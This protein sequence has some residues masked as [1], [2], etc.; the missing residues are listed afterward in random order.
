M[1]R[2]KKGTLYN[3]VFP[4]VDATDGLSIES[5][6]TASD[7]N[8]A[9]TKKWYGVAHGSSTAAS[10]GTISKAT[11]LVHSGIFQQTLNAT[12]TNYDRVIAVFKHASCADQ[13]MIVDFDDYDDSDI[14]SRISDVASDLRSYLVG[15]SGMLSDVDSQLNLNA[16]LA[17]DAHSAA[18]QANSRTLVIQSMVSDVDSQLLLNASMISDVQSA[19]DSQFL[20]VTSNLSDVDS[21]L[22][23]NASMI[24]DVQSAVALLATSNYLSQVH[25]D[26]AS[27]IGAVT[28]TVSASDMSDIASRVWATTEGARVD[29]RVLLIL[30]NV[31][32]VQSAVALL[33]TSNYLSQVHSDLTSQIGAIA[34]TI[35]DSNISD[36]ASAVQAILASDMSDILSAAQQTN[37][38]VLVVQSMVSDV[39]SALTVHDAAMSDAVS[40]VASALTVH[41]A[42]ISN[43]I[44]ALQSDLTSK[45]GLLATSDYLSA[46]HSDIISALG[47]ISLALTASDISDI[48]SAVAAAVTTVTASDISDIA[49][50]VQAI[51]ASDMSDIL[52][53]AQ[54]GNSRVLVV[55]SM[56]S[57]VYSLVSD[58]QSDFQSR[59]PKAV[60]TNSQLSDLHSDLRSQLDLNASMISDIQSA[61]DS[62]FTIVLSN[63]S[64][65]DSEVDLVRAGVIFSRG[66]AQAGN[67]NA[68]TLAASEPSTNSLFNDLT[69]ALV[70]GTGFGQARPV[71]NY[72]GA[73]RIATVNPNWEIA[74]DST[75][76]YILRTDFLGHS[77]I[78]QIQDNVVSLLSRVSDVDSALS[79]QFLAV[80]SMISDVDSQLDLNASMIS[81][82]DSALTLH[83]TN[84]SAAVSD[85]YSLVQNV[86]SQLLVT[87]SLLSDVDSALTL[88]DT[89]MSAALSDVESQVDLLATSNYLSQVH[90]DIMSGLGAVSVTLT[91]SDISDIASA[92]SAEGITVNL[93]ASDMSDI[94][95]RVWTNSTRTLTQSA[96]SVT[97]AV[98]GDTITVYRGTTWTIALTGLGD[99]S[100]YDKIYFSAKAS[101]DD[102]DTEAY[103]RVYNNASGL[104]RINQAA[105]TAA[106]NGTITIDDAAAGDIT[107]TINEAETTGL[108]IISGLSYDIKG[109]DNDGDVDLISIGSK[110][111]N[112]AGD[113]TRAIT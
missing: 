56:T 79:S 82:I 78:E 10:S 96:A 76:S 33:P 61:L 32:D 42:A 54:Q 98:S 55:Q 40:N 52:S 43:S 51:L 58:I 104:E 65:I 22:L 8:S 77:H 1:A 49:S 64:D 2:P 89:N 50:A 18:A 31:S 11:L 72:V 102:A 105:P 83:D 26:L 93:T 4:M 19:L 92:I 91:A 28:A 29:S 44:S 106:T 5:G 30:S 15:M 9:A 85:V 53:A 100:T 80:T 12:E 87:H 67:V 39:G 7:F 13:I 24:S 66:K 16:S 46:V 36:I 86:D 113:V 75:T 17:S 14:M 97:A 88:H 71:I 108:P 45:I 90:S 69:V 107:I 73:T 57:D 48:A 59:V 95:S 6:I 21:Q 99:I 47:N 84:M 63:L 81:D 41:D 27:A 68:I 112:I 103:L 110:E 34:V 101:L 62:Q 38:R 23:L 111:F 20:I 70:A 3:L 60:A 35:T 109:I 37:S 25:S 74:P 94:A